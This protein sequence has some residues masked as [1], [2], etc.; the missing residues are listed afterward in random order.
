VED[1]RD[2]VIV[3]APASEVWEAIQ[4]PS[5]HA[6]WHPALTRIDGEHALG[7]VRKC[8]VMVGKKRGSTEERC[9]TYDEGRMIMWTIEKD[10]TGFS[11]MAS[12]WS[13]GF[14][15]EPQGPDTTRVVARSV[16]NPSAL[17]A[18]LMLPLIR[19]QFHQTQRAILTGLK[20]HVER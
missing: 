12:D 7:A 4:D 15:L 10:S 11:R 2:D 20:Q 13:A 9:S 8:D 6:E 14:T 5:R 19:R 17:L 16:F 3:E 18:R 1:I